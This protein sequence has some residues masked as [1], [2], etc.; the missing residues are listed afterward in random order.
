VVG[1]GLPWLQS[2]L[3]AASGSSIA[4]VDDLLIFVSSQK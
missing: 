1:L 3:S 4:K 2:Q